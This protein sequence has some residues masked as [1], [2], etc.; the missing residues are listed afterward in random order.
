MYLDTYDSGNDEEDENDY[1]HD[2]KDSETEF[3]DHRIS[4]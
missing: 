3:V 4:L 2:S 1:T